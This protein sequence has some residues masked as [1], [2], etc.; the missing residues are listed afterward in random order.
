MSLGVAI[1]LVIISIFFSKT[2][3]NIS[4]QQK[5]ILGQQQEFVSPTPSSI[6]TLI[7]LPAEEATS[8]FKVKDNSSTLQT[9][10]LSD[11]NYPS[12]NQISNVGN[13]LILESNDNP[14][15]ITDWYKEKI[16]SLGFK[17]KSFVQTKTNGNI[18]NKLV[19][20]SAELD[21]ASG[22]IE[23]SVEIKKSAEV[24]KVSITITLIDT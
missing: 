19:A 7:P 4:D 9:S 10:N 23:V 17:S 6:P 1:L 14:D 24:S 12:S 16:R 3:F 5:K 11:F 20:A 2:D 21:S 15:L 18:L 13:T 8:T 22:S